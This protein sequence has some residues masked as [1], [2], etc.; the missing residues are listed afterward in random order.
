MKKNYVLIILTSTILGLLIGIT[1]REYN[2]KKDIYMNK[3]VL[4]KKEIKQN[5]KKLKDLYKSKEALEEKLNDLKNK[6]EDKSQIKQIENMKYILSYTNL[7]EKGITIQI[8]ALNEDI[9]NIANFVDYNKILINLVNE[10]KLNGGKF[11]SINNQRINQYSEIVLAGSHI[12]INSVAIAPP[13]EFKVIGD[14]DKLSNY[15]K[16]NSQYL[17]NIQNNYPIKVENKIEKEI[18]MQKINIPNKLKY[19]EGK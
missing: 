2:D 4:S 11:I 18:H 9:G 16:K 15:I 14:I 3:E 7:K 8:D 1:L 13:Y 5:N 10:I 6:Y 12:N 19:I 17:K